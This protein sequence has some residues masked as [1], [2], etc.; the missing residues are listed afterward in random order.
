MARCASANDRAVPLDALPGKQ[1][2]IDSDLNGGLIDEAEARGAAKRS[3][4]KPSSAARWMGFA[5]HT[6]RRHR[7]H[8]DHL[9][10]IV[11][12]F[13]IGS[14]TGWSPARGD[15]HRAHHRRRLVTVIPL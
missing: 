10:N 8:P 11:A 6:A 12:G 9:I 1:M 4:P 2:S 15:L 3:P 13:L 5:I 7:Q 14:A